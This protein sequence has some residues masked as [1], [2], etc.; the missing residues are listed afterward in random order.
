MTLK[1]TKSTWKFNINWR[2]KLKTKGGMIYHP[3]QCVFNNAVDVGILS[4]YPVINF[5]KNKHMGLIPP[6]SSLDG[7]NIDN[8]DNEIL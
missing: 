6:G 7:M 1:V 2:N 8:D 3:V 5:M 4:L